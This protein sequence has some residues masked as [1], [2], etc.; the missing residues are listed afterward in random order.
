[1][2]KLANRTGE[3]AFFKKMVSGEVSQRILLIE[4]QSGYGKTGLMGRFMTECPEGAIAIDI[5]LKDARESG[6]L[7]LF[8]RS[9]KLLGKQ[10]FQGFDRVVESFQPRRSD[11]TIRGNRLQGE[12]NQIQVVLQDVRSPEERRERIDR[13][14]EAFFEDLEQH[15]SP[16]VFILDTFNAATPELQDQIAG[17]FLTDVGDHQHLRAVVA[18][19]QVPQPSSTWQRHHHIFPLGPIH[20]Y[21]AWYDFARASGFCFELSQVQAMVAGCQ[22][23]PREVVKFFELAERG[24]NQS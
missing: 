10:Y 13:L 5:D 22:G 7:Y 3:L 16:I 14:Q 6:I 9:R 18:G 8:R 23:V 19:S 2:T 11:I 17:G 21:D 20:E 4:A 24:L 12:G 1:M 15:S